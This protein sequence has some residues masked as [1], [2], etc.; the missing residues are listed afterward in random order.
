VTIVLAG[1][2]G[3]LGRALHAR[4][5]RDGHRVITLTRRP[6]PDARDQVAWDP[7]GSV[8]SWSS[9][10]EGAAAVVNLAGEGIA[11]RRWNDARKR[12]LRESRILPTRSLVTAFRIGKHPA[13]MLL[14]GSAVGYYGPHDDE[15]VTEDTPA[16][17]DFLGE[18]CVAW[19]REAEPAAT[20]ARVVWLRTGLVL[21]PDGGALGG[22]LPPFRLGVGGRLGSGRQY[23]PWIH[24]DDWVSLVVWAMTTADARGA[25]N[26]TAPN[27]VTNAE[28]TR[29][30]A[31]AI[32]R[33]AIFP[34]PG[35]AL[36]ILL[37]EFADSLLTGQ[38]AIPARAEQL[39]F[40][41]RFNDLAS[42][43]SD[44][45]RRARQP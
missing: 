21:H 22:M 38:R 35:F 3:F 30:L 24:L 6:R 40:Q 42:A 4:L 18:L 13:S 9:V 41:F 16:G 45:F 7:D 20:Q 44:L 26:G 27:P 5:T 39:G 29:A 12:A 2:S 17:T 32:H 15:V 31:S 11:D 19:E 43:L 25:L 34:V 10:L 1:G 8:G 14:Q 36:R 37:G 33:P 28:F 23:M